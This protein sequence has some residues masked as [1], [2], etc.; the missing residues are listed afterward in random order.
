MRRLPLAITLS[1]AIA[2]TL[3]LTGCGNAGTAQNTPAAGVHATH[4]APAA[5]SAAAALRKRAE[6]VFTPVPEKLAAVRDQTISPAK[7]ELGKMLFFEP[8]LSSSQV[9]SC[10]SCHSLSTAGA[11]NVPTS[12]GHGFQRGPRNAPTVF[13][14][15]F[16][17]AQFWDGRAPDLSEQ[18][19]GPIQAGVEMNNTPAR[20]VA[21]L[22]GIPGYARAFALAFPDSGNNAITFDNM[23]RAIEAFEATLLTP[24]APFDRFLAGD[25]GALDARQ[26]RGMGLFMDAGCVACHNGINVGGQSYHPFGV[27]SK[28]AAHLLPAADTGRFAVTR[29]EGD[30]YAFRAAPLRNV[31]LTAPYFHSGQVWDLREA[32]RIMGSS[33]LGRQLAPAEVE[34]ITAFLQSLSGVAPQVTLPILPPSADATPRP[35][36]G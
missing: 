5:D 25:D 9:I 3:L 15:V 29:A 20:A 26:Q 4:T 23:A 24:G 14:A 19:K 1:P 21:T 8:R 30:E 10:N 2:A 16:N 31:A 17:A 32:V 22:K 36:N 28:P 27:V 13:N 11:D 6:G 35:L 7:V 34:D 33:Q 18:A 12:I